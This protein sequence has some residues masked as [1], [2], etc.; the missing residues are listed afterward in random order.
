[1]IIQA[2]LDRADALLLAYGLG[3][4]RAYCAEHSYLFRPALAELA[5][6]AELGKHGLLDERTFPDNG[7]DGG[8][9]G[10]DAPRFLT[11]RDFAALVGR[12]ERT[13]R[14]WVA[15]GDLAA[16]VAGI[17]ASELERLTKGERLDG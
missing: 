4:L 10:S 3:L 6:Q 12:N 2:E 9:A 8:D 11:R 15:R 1:M 16:T 13:I 17:P 14:R 5:R 7:R